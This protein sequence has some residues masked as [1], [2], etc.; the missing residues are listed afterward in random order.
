MVNPK[1]ANKNSDS[2]QYKIPE[3]TVDFEALAKQGA[4]AYR[5]EA[6]DLSG[7]EG[8]LPWIDRWTTFIIKTALTIFVASLIVWWIGFVMLVVKCEG[9]NN[10]G[11]HLDPKVLITLLSTTTINILVMMHAIVKHF[12]PSK[13]DI[14]PAK[15]G[16]SA[17]K[18]Q[19]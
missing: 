5:A 11:F 12:F 3:V 13:S 19:K 14:L 15:S 8:S 7:G 4:G 10:K 16:K 1:N 18:A 17:K 6:E 9:W 2:C